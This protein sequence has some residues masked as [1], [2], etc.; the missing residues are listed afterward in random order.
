MIGTTLR[1]QPRASALGQHS[2][3]DPSQHKRERYSL[4]RVFEFFCDEVQV[5]PAMEEENDVNKQRVQ[6]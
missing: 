2:P 1:P 6:T 4:V 3:R 5:V